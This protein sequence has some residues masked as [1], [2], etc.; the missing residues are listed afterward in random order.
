MTDKITYHEVQVLEY[1]TDELIERNGQF[2]L[3][4]RACHG[5]Y[6]GMHRT[7]AKRTYN[8]GV[9]QIRVYSSFTSARLAQLALN[10][11]EAVTVIN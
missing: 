8:R 11:Y 1:E 2:I 5:Y 7:N 4:Y 9:T 3:S 10:E 6:P